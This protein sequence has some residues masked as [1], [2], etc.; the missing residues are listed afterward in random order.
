LTSRL[1]PAPQEE[2]RVFAEHYHLY[3]ADDVPQRDLAE[4]LACEGYSVDTPLRGKERDTGRMVHRL[5]LRPR[6]LLE[7]GEV[8]GDGG[9]VQRRLSDGAELGA[10]NC[11]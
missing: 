8:M 3:Y 5:R 2:L 9:D 6:G 7:S 11:Q 1:R 4:A 10:R